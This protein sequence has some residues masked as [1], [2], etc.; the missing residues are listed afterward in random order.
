MTGDEYIRSVLGRYE[1]PRGPGSTTE[2]VGGAL[3][4][5]LARWAGER[6]NGVSY[7]GSYAKGT[8]VRGCTDVDLF[9]S[10]KPALGA[11]LRDLYWEV[12]AKAGEAGLT[13][14][15]QDVSVGVTYQ[16]VNV[17]LVPAR[18]QPDTHTYHSLYRRKKD[19]WTQTNP[20]LHINTVIQSGRT[21]E[22]RAIKIWRQ[23]H[24][25]EFPSFYLELSVISALQGRPM[26][27]ID[28]NIWEVLRYLGSEFAERVIVDPANS[29]N[30]VS[31]DLTIAEKNMIRVAALHSRQA[32]TWEG[33]IR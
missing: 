22:I 13:P 16:G 1:V 32:K 17:D 11:T 23:I 21:Q 7:S 25:L 9:I 29:N 15:P 14:R 2:G 8:G 31:D 10:F 12:F 30:R 18:L 26:D 19:S 4:T 6:L 24:S 20:T 33:I 3:A 28:T 5:W 27:T